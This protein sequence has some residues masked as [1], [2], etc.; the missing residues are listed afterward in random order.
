MDK[1]SPLLKTRTRYRDLI[2]S[3]DS[4]IAM[5]NAAE[6]KSIQLAQIEQG[7]NTLLNSLK[8]NKQEETVSKEAGN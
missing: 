5:K 8:K 7:C 1:L 3:A 6:Q 2:D 4:V